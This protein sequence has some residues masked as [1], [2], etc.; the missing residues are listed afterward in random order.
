[1][2]DHDHSCKCN[3]FPIGMGY[4]PWQEF[5]NLHDPEKGLHAGTIFMELEKPFIGRRMYRR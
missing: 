3:D 5:K 4:I 2:C 1:M